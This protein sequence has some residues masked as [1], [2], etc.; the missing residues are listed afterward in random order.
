MCNLKSNKTLSEII[1]YKKQL[2][3]INQTN[4]TFV[5]F[6][7]SIYLPFFYNANYAIGSQNIS[8]YGSGNHT[9]EILA[10]QLSSL[11]VSYCLINHC[12]TEETVK[13]CI[14]K[15]KNATLENI[16]VVYCVGKNIKQ[17]LGVKEELKK[18]IQSVF[19]YLTKE[20]QENILIAYEP[21]W[22]I[23]QTDTLPPEEIE[24]TIINIKRYVMLKY[25]LNIKV[26]YGGSINLENI[27]KLLNIDILDGYLIG[28]SGINPENMVKM[29]VKF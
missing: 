16:K 6:P 29:S 14:L 17:S 18:Q 8:I 25:N 1:A 4:K 13:D 24:D 28:N 22:A 2:K 23:N 9:G 10:T 26:L 19:D 11:N 21:F 5:L 27:D 20:E 3:N 7:S 12:E 15:I